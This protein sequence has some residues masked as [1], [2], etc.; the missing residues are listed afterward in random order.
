MG[1]RSYTSYKRDDSIKVPILAWLL[2]RSILYVALLAVGIFFVGGVFKSGYDSFQKVVAEPEVVTPYQEVTAVNSPGMDW[3]AQFISLKPP[4]VEDW[5]VS[6][7]RSPRHPFE[8]NV[9][10]IQGDVAPTVT[11]TYSATGSGIETR[12]QVY[13][14][15]QAMEQFEKYSE[16]YQ[17]CFKGLE[18]VE[19]NRGKV[20][21]FDNGFVATFGDT[22]IGVSM[23]NVDTGVRDQLLEFYV[24]NAVESLSNSGC[25]ALN[26]EVEDSDRSFFY[27]PD[28]YTGLTEIT[29]VSSK[30]DVSDFAEPKVFELKTL[31]NVYVSEPESPLPE[32]FPTMPDAVSQP[33]FPNSVDEVQNFDQK[34]EYNIADVYGPGCGWAWSGQK[35]PI[36]DDTALSLA[37]ERSLIEAQIAS[38]MAALSYSDRKRSWAFDVALLLPQA[39][40]WNRYVDEVNKVYEKWDWLN[41]ER[42][43]LRG[44]WY[45]YVAE[46]DEWLGFD[47]LRQEAADEYDKAL[48]QC[49]AQQDELL[50]WE[51]TWGELYDQQ[52]LA[53]NNPDPEPTAD[54][55]VEPTEEEDGSGDPTD[56]PTSSPRPTPSPS[57][58]IPKVDIPPRP[59]GCSDIPERPSILDMSRPSEPQPPSIPDGVTIPDSWAKPGE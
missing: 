32:D 56:E 59:N 37:K 25:I 45:Q 36:Y 15:G 20:L 6:E 22:I 28:S 48:E 14:A 16:N 58:E 33:S 23:Q 43:V 30:L 24:E 39:D 29:T 44:P 2:D 47:D 1:R 26:V 21:K 10:N 49:L 50:D 46:Y 4:T 41:S 40:E 42:A 38:D 35:S 17:N 9:C 13:G 12:V 7:S 31:Q 11:S 54:P 52:E 57:P 18:E 34:A 53:R 5:T 19:N 8:N 27:K 51:D 55:T 3:A